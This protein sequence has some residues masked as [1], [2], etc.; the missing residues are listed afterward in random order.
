MK[1]KLIEVSGHPREEGVVQ[2]VYEINFTLGCCR[3]CRSVFLRRVAAVKLLL[4]CR[5]SRQDTMGH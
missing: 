3:G 5:C 1:V 4:R 2:P